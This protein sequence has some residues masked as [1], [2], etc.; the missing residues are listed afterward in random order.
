MTRRWLFFALLAGLL[1]GALARQNPVAASSPPRWGAPVPIGEQLPSSWFPDIQADPSGAFR[2]VWN[3]NL[4]EGDGN[5]THAFT[6]AVMQNSSKSSGD[7]SVFSVTVKFPSQFRLYPKLTDSPRVTS[8][9]TS[10]LM[11][12]V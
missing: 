7:W 5:L 9:C 8:C 11:S 4:A 1:V 12:H 10:T 3:A 2:L 6:G